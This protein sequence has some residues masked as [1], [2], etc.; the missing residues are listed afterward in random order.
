ML[1]QKVLDL[2]ADEEIFTEATFRQIVQ[3]LIGEMEINSVEHIDLRIGPSVGR[4]HWMS[5]SI[6]GLDI[7]QDEL[8][9]HHDLSIAFL[10]GINM[11]KPTNTLDGIFDSLLES[12]D[13]LGRLAG[14]DINFLS[15]DIFKFDRYVHT[16]N[17]L[18]ASGLKVNIHLGELF[19]NEVSRYVLSRIT[20]DRIGHGVLLLQDKKLSDFIRDHEICLD[21]CPTS[22]TLLG[23]VDWGQ[24]NPARRALDLGIPISI[25]PD[26]PLLFGTD[27]T[28]EIRNSRLRDDELGVIAAYGRKYRY[29]IK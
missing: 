6:D 8:D 10:A 20:P 9:R 3:D 18:Q 21:M 17:A 5:S 7:F 14:V 2:T 12:G 1:W 15:T 23:V 27:M 4:W 24:D 26:D 28:R 13:L 11:T 19:D 29:E 22:N 16:L 25:N